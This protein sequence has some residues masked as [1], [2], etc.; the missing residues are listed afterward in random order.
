MYIC[1]NQNWCINMYSAIYRKYLICNNYK[2]QEKTGEKTKRIYARMKEM[3]KKIK[4]RKKTMENKQK[5]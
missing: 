2:I 3:R 5:K 1:N 4:G